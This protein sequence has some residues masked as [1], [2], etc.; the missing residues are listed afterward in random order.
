[1]LLGFPWMPP[2]VIPASS[3]DTGYLSEGWG[4]MGMFKNP[5]AAV[6][7]SCQTAGIKLASG[8]TGAALLHPGLPCQLSSAGAVGSAPKHFVVLPM[9]QSLRT[10]Q[11]LYLILSP[12]KSFTIVLLKEVTLHTRLLC[13]KICV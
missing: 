13:C 8:D 1:M 3:I 9:G 5:K 6:R 2:I 11:T 12:P 4:E 7:G 10:F